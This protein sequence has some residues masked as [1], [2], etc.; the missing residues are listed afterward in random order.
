MYEVWD[1]LGRDPRKVFE[2]TSM[3]KILQFIEEKDN[4]I[5]AEIVFPNGSKY[6]WH[7]E[8]T[9]VEIYLGKLMLEIEGGKICC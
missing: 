7:Q 6:F 3:D 5:E 8:L 9:D 2:S 4:H 1:R